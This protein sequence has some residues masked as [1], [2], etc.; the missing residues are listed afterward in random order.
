[1]VF[2]GLGERPCFDDG[3][4]GRCFPPWRRQV[5]T[6]PLDFCN[7]LGNVLLCDPG[8]YSSGSSEVCWFWVSLGAAP[9]QQ[10]TWISQLESREHS[11]YLVSFHLLWSCVVLCA[12]ICSW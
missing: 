9:V 3:V 10:K 2:R 7:L 5:K 12:F 1:M 4:L 11:F 8:G 6:L